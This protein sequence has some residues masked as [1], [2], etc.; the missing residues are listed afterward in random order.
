MG[1]NG[2]LEFGALAHNKIG[3]TGA[4]IELL[5]ILHCVL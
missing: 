3:P 2:L 4:A 5:Y 1:S